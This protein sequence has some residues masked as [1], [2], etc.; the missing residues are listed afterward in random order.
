MERI[1]TELE[2]RL[3]GER[4]E[5]VLRVTELAKKYAAQ[6]GISVY[7]AEQAALLHDIAKCMDKESLRHHLQEGKG[8][9]RLFDFHP[10]LWHGPVGAL[11]AKQEFGIDNV[12]VL[13]AIHYHTTGRAHMSM[14][15]KIIYVADL[16]EPERSFPGV[17]QLRKLANESIDDAMK[18]SIC[19]S[20]EYLVSKR[21]AI[22]PDSFDCY[23][24][25]VLK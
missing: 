17:E 10:E 15:E 16:L 9:A 18:A 4:L 11:L 14:L 2:K 8:D 22:Y 3:T 21:V 12:D 5:H 1:K 23:N 13:N 7:D 20:I 24:H 6:Y 25:F 19:H